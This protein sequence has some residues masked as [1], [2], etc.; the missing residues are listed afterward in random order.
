MS[1][2]EQRPVGVYGLPAQGAFGGLFWQ[3]SLFGLCEILALVGLIAAFH[4]YSFGSLAEHG[5]DIAKWALLWSVFF[6][7]GRFV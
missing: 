2:I 1:L 3:G 7:R 6:L 4:G 5:A